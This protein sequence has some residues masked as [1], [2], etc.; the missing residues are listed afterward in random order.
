[1]LRN[2]PG[3]VQRLA[4]IDP[5]HCEITEICCSCLSTIQN[6]YTGSF[7]QLSLCSRMYA[8]GIFACWDILL[9]NKFRN[10]INLLWQKKKQFLFQNQK[11]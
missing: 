10:N 3:S 7:R 2:T 6:F 1:V 11:S 9:S 5:I 4:I 8:E